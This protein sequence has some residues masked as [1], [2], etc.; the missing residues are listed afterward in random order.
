MCQCVSLLCAFVILY[1][2]TNIRGNPDTKPFFK[3][4]KSKRTICQLKTIW[5]SHISD[6]GLQQV[7]VLHKFNIEGKLT[8]SNAINISAC[9]F[10]PL[11][12]MI[13]IFLFNNLAL[14]NTTFMRLILKLW[15]PKYYNPASDASGHCIFATAFLLNL[16]DVHP[17][18]R[19][20]QKIT[21]CNNNPVQTSLAF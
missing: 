21:I 12:V 1:T 3:N 14:K 6:I 20:I 5:M 17:K 16:K 2:D 19:P 9:T 7:S 11:F 15:F 13:L 10:F 8:L 18:Q 4:T